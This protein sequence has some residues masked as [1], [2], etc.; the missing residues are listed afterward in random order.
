MEFNNP[1]NEQAV[2]TGIKKTYLSVRLFVKIIYR[3]IR[4][5]RWFRRIVIMPFVKPFIKFV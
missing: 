4:I 3:L 2:K 1:V 5:P